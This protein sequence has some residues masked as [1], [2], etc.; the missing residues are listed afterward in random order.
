MAC[1]HKWSLHQWSGIRIEHCTRCG[2]TKR[3]DKKGIIHLTD[4]D[5]NHMPCDAEDGEKAIRQAERDL[6]RIRN[7]E[8]L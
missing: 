4:A 1:K 7:G 2:A 6:A 3:I 8:Y 5:G